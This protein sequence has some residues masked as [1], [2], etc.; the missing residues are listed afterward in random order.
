ME[1]ST[2]S[3]GLPPRGKRL[4]PEL[5]VATALFLV[6]LA[7]GV[8]SL[9]SLVRDRRARDGGAEIVSTSTVSAR[10]GGRVGLD[11]L[12]VV[13][14]PRG[15]LSEDTTVSLSKLEGPDE[16]PTLPDSAVPVGPAIRL[17]L[18]RASLRGP[19]TIR[20]FYDPASLPVGTEPGGD[21]PEGA[22]AGPGVGGKGGRLVVFQ[23]GEGGSE[24]SP[25][26]GRSEG[27][28]LV[29]SAESPGLFRLG[30]ISPRARPCPIAQ[31]ASFCDFV[32]ELD[33]AIR[34]G[35]LDKVASLV[36][37]EP[38]RCRGE[39]GL[40]VAA[41]EGKAPGTVVEVADYSACAPTE[42]ELLDRA[43]YETWAA[44]DFASVRAV[45]YPQAVVVRSRGAMASGE[46]PI[47][48][49]Y[50]YV[51]ALG[52]RAGEW[53]VEKTL[54]RSVGPSEWE[55]QLAE[56]LCSARSGLVEWPAG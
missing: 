25:L 22:G 6:V 38:H 42:G 35:D 48:G 50:E 9:F 33:G 23:L 8:A 37:F 41:C 3:E 52:R 46:G 21:S 16:V 36:A 4:R 10:D 54:L 53:R 2:G 56:P 32:N 29:A 44:A 28:Q 45:V 1:E 17:E 7:V 19:V 55:G 26:P 14:I 24:W 15:A 5:V 39:E 49:D 47:T 31:D 11:G 40:P 51:L 12:V 20:F 27:G 34:A 30:V 13:E 18:G 43:V